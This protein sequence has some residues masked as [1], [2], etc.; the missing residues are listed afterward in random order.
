MANLTPEEKEEMQRM[1]MIMNKV[2]D[3]PAYLLQ[4][5]MMLEAYK[6]ERQPV[7]TQENW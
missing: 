1:Q 7:P 5:K 4:R 3:D 6:R 2:P